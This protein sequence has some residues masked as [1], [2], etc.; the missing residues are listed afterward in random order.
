MYELF[1]Q[2]IL[3]KNESLLLYEWYV[4]FKVILNDYWGG[5]KEIQ[6]YQLVFG[7]IGR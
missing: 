7:G 1:K 3:D 2:D 4:G 6:V 5:V